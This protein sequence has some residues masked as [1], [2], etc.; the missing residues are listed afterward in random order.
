M[1][2]NTYIDDADITEMYHCYTGKKIIK[3]EEFFSYIK[4]LFLVFEKE[5]VTLDYH[6]NFWVGMCY[7]F[8][9]YDIYSFLKGKTPS[10]EK[11]NSL[12]SDEELEEEVTL[13]LEF[14]D[15][16]DVLVEYDIAGLTSDILSRYLKS[17]NFTFFE[18]YSSEGDEWGFIFPI[19]SKEE[20]DEE[21][22]NYKRELLKPFIQWAVSLN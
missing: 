15:E 14:L 20:D 7:A 2:N 19:P 3:D 12:L 13:V 16:D 1:R 21:D 6:K 17:G 18:G 9:E 10:L 5:E 8:P 4:E 11:F 22:L